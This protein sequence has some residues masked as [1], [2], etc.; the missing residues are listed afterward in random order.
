MYSIIFLAAASF[1]CCLVLTPL[2]RRWSQWQGVVDQPNTKRKR[3]STPIP[4]TGGIAIALAYVVA[5][6]LLVNSP[7]R[8]ADSVNL[9][10]ATQSGQ[11]QGV[12][13]NLIDQS[14]NPVGRRVNGPLRIRGEQVVCAGAAAANLLL[15]VIG[16][17]IAAHRL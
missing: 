17:F 9:P 5:L 16:R 4:R 13:A 1:A 2:V 7:L 3:H 15:H 14:W 11:H 10:L 8:G 6:T 12:V